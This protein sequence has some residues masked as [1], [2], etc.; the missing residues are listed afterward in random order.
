MTSALPVLEYLKKTVG[1]HKFRSEGKETQYSNFTCEIER[2]IVLEGVNGL[3]VPI[4]T[5]STLVVYRDPA[6][7]YDAKMAVACFHHVGAKEQTVIMGGGRMRTTRLGLRSLL[8]T[9]RRLP[10]LNLPHLE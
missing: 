8:D 3:R 6:K 4:P 1:S 10:K 7:V 9:K 2:S 5:G